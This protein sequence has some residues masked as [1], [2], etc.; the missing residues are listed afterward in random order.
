MKQNSILVGS[1]IF[2]LL[3]VTFGQ[4]QGQYSMYMVNQYLLN[5][6]VTGTEDYADIKAGFRGQWVGLSDAPNSYYLTGHTPVGKHLGHKEHEG[7]KPLPW[8]SL[9]GMINGENTG[10]L[11]KS[12]VYMSYAYHIPLR[13]DMN[14]SLGAFIGGQQYRVKTEQLRFDSRGGQDNVLTQNAIATS[15]DG[16]VGLW[17]YGKKVFTGISSLQV[18][19]NKIDV[20]T[21]QEASR[22]RLNRHYFFTAGY[23]IKVDSNWSLVPS[24]MVK[25]IHPAPIS[26]D[27]NCKVRYKDM[28]WGGFSWRNQDAVIVIAGFTWDKRW[29]IGYSYDYTTSRLG[30]YS[31]GTHEVVVGYRW[32]H[33]KHEPA[34]AQFW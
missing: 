21:G 12:G 19:N 6:G 17:L 32:H 7:V 16:S 24:L 26:V 10:P 20:S 27:L 22:S 25:G 4:Q 14:I 23:R 31:S 8:H 15:P 34:P 13:T 5:P 28:L 30:Q 29:D 2:S 3:K 9:G 18:F 1:L 33:L 11:N